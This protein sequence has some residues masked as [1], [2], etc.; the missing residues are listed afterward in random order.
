M[1]EAQYYEKKAE[2]LSEKTGQQ[3]TANHVEAWVA[4]GEYVWMKNSEYADMAGERAI[5][6]ATYATSATL[7][8]DD[9]YDP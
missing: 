3:I 1:P 2:E 7:D 4:N 5:N 8:V 6:Y 9:H